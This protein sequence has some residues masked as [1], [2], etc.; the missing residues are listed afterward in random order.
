MAGPHN[1]EDSTE[2]F[3]YLVQ[4]NRRV[5][6]GLHETE[7]FT[8]EAHDKGVIYVRIPVDDGKKTLVSPQVYEEIY[9]TL[10]DAVLHGEKIAIHCGQGDGRSGTAVAA[11]KIHELLE[12]EVRHHPKTFKTYPALSTSIFGS[13]TTHR[14]A[15]TPLVRRAIESVRHDVNLPKG[16]DSGYGEESVESEND[17]LSLVHY[18][19]FLRQSLTIEKA[20]QTLAGLSVSSFDEDEAKI[21]LINHLKMD[22]SN[23]AHREYWAEK[24]SIL[25]TTFHGHK[26]P[27]SV[28]NALVAIEKNKDKPYTELKTAIKTTLKTPDGLIGSFFKSRS[29]HAIQLLKKVDDVDFINALEGRQLERNTFNS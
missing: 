11:I 3:D 16:E 18:E 24:T 15:C 20:N 28:K 21:F 2:V 7:D 22:F 5:L 27:H 12:E 29:E 4:N 6:V 14:V 23:S 8:K 13:E 10:K 26:V 9:V 19:Q 1:N 25:G 17:I